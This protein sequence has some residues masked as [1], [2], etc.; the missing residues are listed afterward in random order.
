LG[1]NGENEPE[2]LGGAEGRR[3]GGNFAVESSISSANSETKPSSFQLMICN[4]F[5][6]CSPNKTIK[7]FLSKFWKDNV[8]R[9]IR[10]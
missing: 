6:S 4:I 5:T 8:D 10:L 2:E 1:K 3:R 7:S 9:F